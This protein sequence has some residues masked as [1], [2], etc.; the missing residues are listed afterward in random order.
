M[1]KLRTAHLPVASDLF[2][3]HGPTEVDRGLGIP[4]ITSIDEHF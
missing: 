4:G 2:P 3:L 1:P